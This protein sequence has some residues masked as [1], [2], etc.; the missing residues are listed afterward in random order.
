MRRNIAIVTGGGGNIGVG[1]CR[2]L[3]KAGATVVALDLDASGADAAARAIDADVTD[4]AACASAVEDVVQEFGGVDTLVNLAQQFRKARPVAEVTDEDMRVSFESGPIA[5]LRMMQLCYPHMKARGGGSVVNFASGVG[6]GGMLGATAYA[7]AKEAIRGLT[8]VA[9]LEWGPDNI[10]V[11]V[12]C[13]VASGDPAN[14]P[15]VLGALSI[16]P[17]GRV[18]DPEA[19]IGSAVVYL[20]GPGRY[21]TGRT[22][23]VDGGVGCWR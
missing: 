22:L 21:V 1:V 9:A 16:N 12:I 4:P 2:A 11:N 10:N 23:Q 7:S 19:D 15:W 3:A 13:P 18:G 20:A 17:M 14:A 6:T 8:K 5:S